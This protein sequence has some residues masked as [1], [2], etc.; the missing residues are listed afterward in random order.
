MNGSCTNILSFG[1]ISY[2]NNSDITALLNTM[3]NCIVF[4][5]RYS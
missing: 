2:D 4:H 1:H 3:R 5:G